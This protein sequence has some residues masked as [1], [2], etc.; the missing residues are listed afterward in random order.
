MQ[1]Y[2]KKRQSNGYLLQEQ[3]PQAKTGLIF[4]NFPKK[5]LQIAWHI[6]TDYGKMLACRSLGDVAKCDIFLKNE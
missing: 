2:Q 1:S 5:V 3:E 6:L 4:K